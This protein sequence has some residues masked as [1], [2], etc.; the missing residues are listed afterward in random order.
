MACRKKSSGFLSKNWAYTQYRVR[1]IDSSD[2][3]KRRGDPVT[4]PPVA[5]VWVVARLILA[6]DK[7]EAFK[8]LIFD[9]AKSSP[10]YQGKDLV[11]VMA[12]P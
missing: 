3:P 11:I 2:Y 7:M 8:A 1:I 10:R 4:S 6:D 12:R 9:Q 5:L